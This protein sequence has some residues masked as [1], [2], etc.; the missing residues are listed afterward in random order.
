LSTGV[1]RCWGY[2]ADGELGDGTVLNSQPTPTAAQI[3][4]VKTIAAGGY[5]TC[6]VTMTGGL[7]CWGQ[8]GASQV[9]TL[10]DVDS[11]EPLP[12]ATDILTGVKSVAGGL[13]HTCAL[14]TTG[15]VR[16]WGGNSDGELGTGTTTSITTPPSTDV[17]TGVQA[18]A[19]GGY[20]TCA[21]T[22]AG[23]VRCWGNNGYG[24]LGDGSLDN[25]RL[26]PTPEVLTDV[27]AITAGVY[28]TCALTRAGTVRCWGWNQYGQLGDGTLTNRSAPSTDVAINTAVQAIAAGGGFTCALTAGGS[29]RCWGDNVNGELGDGLVV[30]QRSTPGPD[31]PIGAPVKGIATGDSHACVVTTGGSIQCWGANREGQLG[32][33]RTAMN[34]L[35]P[36][37]VIGLDTL[38][39]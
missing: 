9:G 28:H 25:V 11:S 35:T 23:A 22:N 4:G 3:A 32:D 2:N 15:G 27:Q 29:V 36:G 31:V 24:Q 13:V 5:H 33:G 39:P 17:L 37:G 20:H 6:A 26:S 38:C 19:A 12:S 34:R 7:R 16:C 14:M 1:V 8:N 10:P 21:L 18:I 30:G